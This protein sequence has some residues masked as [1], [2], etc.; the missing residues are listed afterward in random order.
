MFG[1]GGVFG[2]FNPGWGIWSGIGGSGEAGQGKGSLI[3][4]FA[5]F[6][7]AAAGV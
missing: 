6:L 3:S 7:T 5:C 4:T 2:A 1:T